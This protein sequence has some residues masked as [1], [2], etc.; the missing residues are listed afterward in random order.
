[1]ILSEEEAK[2]LKYGQQ[3]DV[4]EASDDQIILGMFGDIPIALIQASHGKGQPIRVF[5]L[6]KHETDPDTGDG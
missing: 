6:L 1:M 2:R 3:I 5:N 4:P